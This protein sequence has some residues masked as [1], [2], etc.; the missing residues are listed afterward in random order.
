MIT[1][2]LLRDRLWLLCVVV[3][4]TS[5]VIVRYI[6]DTVCDLMNTTPSST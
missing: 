5:T 6:R 4:L 2:L 1:A 3:F